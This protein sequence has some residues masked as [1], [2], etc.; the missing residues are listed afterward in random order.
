MSYGSYNTSTAEVAGSY[1]VNDKVKIGASYN[2][3]QS[4]GYNLTPAQYRNANLVATASKADNIAASVFLTPNENLKLFAKAYW[5]QTYEDGL[6]WTYRPQQLVDLSAA[7]RAA[8][9]SSTR[10]SR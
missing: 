8:A 1:V 6:V 9:T 7:G 10:T 2:H 4:S 5:N 3:A